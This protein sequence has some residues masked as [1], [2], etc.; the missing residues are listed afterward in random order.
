MRRVDLAAPYF[1]RRELNAH[2]LCKHL[3]MLCETGGAVQQQ[4]AL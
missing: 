4:R 2:G 3:A 1:D